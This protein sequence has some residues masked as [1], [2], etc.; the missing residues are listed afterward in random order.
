VRTPGPTRRSSTSAAAWI[1]EDLI[2]KGVCPGADTNEHAFHITGG[3]DRTILRH[4][5]LIDFKSH[6]K[7]NLDNTTSRIWP[8]DTWYLDNVFMDTAPQPGDKPFNALNLDGGR[9]HIVR[10]NLFVDLVAAADHR[11]SAI[12]PKITTRDMVVE[13]NLIV[14]SK[15]VSGGYDRAGISTGEAWNPNPYCD[16]D[17]ANVGNV[18]RNNIIIGCTGPGNSFG[19]G[20]GY[21]KGT[22]Y[23]HNTVQGAKHNYFDGKDDSSGADVVF[24]ANVLFADWLFDGARRPTEVGDLIEHAAGAAAL[25]ADAD[26]GDFTLKDGSAIRGQATRDPKAP[27]DFCGHCRAATTDIGAIDYGDPRAAECV[28]RV[29]ALYDG[30]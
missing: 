3:A 16:G 7:L 8:N 10:G 9:R 13:Q 11:A 28:A 25:F 26:H 17:C 15:H 23:L 22:T 24:G 18:Y 30:L 20:V 29:K 1:F 12:Y 4:N 6:V 27:H 14:C 5:K 19:I 2:I 21:E